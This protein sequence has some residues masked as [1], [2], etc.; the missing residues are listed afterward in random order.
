M[1]KNDLVGNALPKQ[2]GFTGI[3][4]GGSRHNKPLLGSLDTYEKA[5]TL[6]QGAIKQ[7][8]GYSETMKVS[9][10]ALMGECMSE[11]EPEDDE[12]ESVEFGAQNIV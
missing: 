1:S 2:L 10:L 11:V 9:F 5:W 7:H 4:G 8:E 12:T 6:L 3:K